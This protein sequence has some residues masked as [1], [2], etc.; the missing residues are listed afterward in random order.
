MEKVV[1]VGAGVAG[2]SCLNAFL[3]RHESPL[4]LEASTIGAPKMCGEFLASSAVNQLKQWD[5]GPLQVIKNAR[6][7]G[8]TRIL[9]VNLPREAGA[10]ARHHAEME[11]AAR[12]K[13]KEGRIM[14]NSPIHRI[15]P[16]TQ[17]SPFILH[18]V[19]GKTIE[20]RDVIFA[21]GKFTQHK[22][23]MNKPKYLG[24]KT[25]LPQIFQP[26]T[27]LMYSLVGGYLGIVPISSETSN[28]TCLIKRDVINKVG[29][30]KEYLSDFFHSLGDDTLNTLDWLEG[31]APE[32]G[33]KTIPN[34]PHAYW[35]G[36]ALASVHPAIGY[37]FAH[38]VNSALLAV[39]YYLK[40]DPVGYHQ[41][42][43]KQLRPKRIVGK[44]M[45]HL[46]QKP[47]LCNVISPLLGAN[48]WISHQ[49]LKKLDY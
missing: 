25:H 41:S 8:D 4:L 48:P 30:C 49:L 29:S 33:S 38:S 12:A 15:V 11:L 44:C 36:D 18:L 45:H 35:I 17:N 39:A 32:F 7:I 47:R 3:D 27:L 10:Y 24:F 20:A 2:L 40:D 37:G 28:L 23:G 31:D 22:V 21:T 14:E 19:S 13:R 34:W 43:M 1:I 6:F 16:A 46:L 26:E 9:H 42:I 5:V